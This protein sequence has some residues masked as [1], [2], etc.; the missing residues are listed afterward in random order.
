MSAPTITPIKLEEPNCKQSSYNDVVP[1]PRCA[2][3]YADPVR[4][5]KLYYYLI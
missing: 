2:L 3:C 5:A 1:K 4:Q